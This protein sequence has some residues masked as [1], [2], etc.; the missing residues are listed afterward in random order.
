MHFWFIVA[1]KNGSIKS[2]SDTIFSIF[3]MIFNTVESFYNK[4]F[5]YPSCKTFWVVQNSFPIVTNLNNMIVKKKA[6]SI[7]TFDFGRICVTKILIF[8]YW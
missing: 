5:F 7:S 3:K 1:S 6:K 4:N 8:F 2:Q